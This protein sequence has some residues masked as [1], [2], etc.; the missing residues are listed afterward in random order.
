MVTINSVS[1]LVHLVHCRVHFSRG[2]GSGS[3]ASVSA[4]DF[5][6]DVPPPHYVGL[7]FLCTTYYQE[8]SVV[9]VS[10]SVLV[11]RSR[12]MLR[13]NEQWNVRPKVLFVCVVF[14]VDSYF[15]V[16]FTIWSN[17]FRVNA[18]RKGNDLKVVVGTNTKILSS[19]SRCIT[20]LH[21]CLRFPPKWWA[22]V[23]FMRRVSI[24]LQV[25]AAAWRPFKQVLR[26]TR[27]A[28]AYI[29]VNVIF[30]MILNWLSG[31]SSITKP[32]VVRYPW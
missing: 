26:F 8:C 21:Q 6:H 12:R 19:C 27:K 29:L 23:F 24:L 11:R 31:V 16:C 9:W 13:V 2:P 7:F 1:N 10:M 28:H 18:D 4:G 20:A 15:I 3:H 25:R 32:R 17:I 22:S 14:H 5:D 30:S